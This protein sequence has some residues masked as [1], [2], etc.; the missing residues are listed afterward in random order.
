MKSLGLFNSILFPCDIKLRKALFSCEKYHDYLFLKFFYCVTLLLLK[1]F[2]CSTFGSQLW[3]VFLFVFFFFPPWQWPHPLLGLM[4]I[5]SPKESNNNPKTKQNSSGALPGFFIRFIQ[6]L[7]QWYPMINIILYSKVT[8]RSVPSWDDM[9]GI[10]LNVNHITG[11]F[12]NKLLNLAKSHL[13][14]FYVQ[15]KKKLKYNI[16][17]I[18]HSS[19]FILFFFNL[20]FGIQYLSRHVKCYFIDNHEFTHKSLTIIEIT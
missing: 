6:Q 20:F 12:E 3:V 5:N 17:L 14:M 19:N 15:S 11:E 18:N 2:S 8:W 13:D 16:T 1:I 7:H 10:Q 4:C 9:L